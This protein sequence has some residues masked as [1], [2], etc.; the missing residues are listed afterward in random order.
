MTKPK[1]LLFTAIYLPGT[2]GG[3]PIKTINNLVENIN[4]FSFKVFT[5]DR[6]LG[7]STPY[8]RIKSATWT[9]LGSA[10]VFYS[11]S[12]IK[13]YKQII[14]QVFKEDYDIVY[15]NSF[16]SL[17]F[18]IFPLILSKLLRKPIILAPRGELSKG[19][20]SLKSA[21]KKIYIAFYKLL[22]ITHSVVFQASSQH[23]ASDIKRNLGDVDIFI[24]ENIGGQQVINFI[25]DR[26]TNIFRGICVCR[27]SPMKNLILALEIL[28]N[29]KKPIVYDIYG[30]IEDYDYW[31]QCKEIISSLPSHISVEFKGLLNSDDVVHRMSSYDFFFMPTK[32]ENY[33]HVI[34]EALCAGLPLVISDATPWRN[35][36]NLGIGWDLPLDNLDAFIEVIDKLTM[37]SADH[38][39]E[40]RKTVLAWAKQKFAQRDAI[41][42]NI[43]M[44]RYTYNKKKGIN[45]AI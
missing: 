30:P 13:F 45:N 12:G 15:L 19:A 2:K 6:D 25:P 11:Q 31:D 29:V 37:M 18:S 10:Q 43:S 34:A 23:E 22:N 44:F 3:G 16:F 20:L 42:A 4:E 26:S 17:K 39:Y 32:G 36:E 5:K 35:L 38:H 24:A 9:N 27:I 33:G 8:P 28:R 21:K 41:E 14:T 40:M 1:V 7:D